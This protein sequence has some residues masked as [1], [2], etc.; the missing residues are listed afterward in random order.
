MNDKTNY[1]KNR[2]Y[3]HLADGR[4]LANMPTVGDMIFGTEQEFKAYL[5]G[6]LSTKENFKLIED[7]LRHAVAKHPKFCEG[8]TD[9]L[10]GM[11]WAEREHKVKAHNAHHAPTAESVLM[12]EIAEAFNAYQH[13][14][15]QNALKEFAQCGAVIFRIMEFIQKEME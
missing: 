10:T 12:E 6:Y 8:F 5:D 7:E 4:I 11:C 15:K 14:D 9:D 3:Y 1:Y 13:G 2:A